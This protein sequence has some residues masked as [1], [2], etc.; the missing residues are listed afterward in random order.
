MSVFKKTNSKNTEI[1][2]QDYYEVKISAIWRGFKQEHISF[3][4][5]CAYFF[6]EYVRPQD[7]YPV[8]EI[9]PWGQIAL[10]ATLVTVFM[11]SSVKWVSNIENKLIMAF[12]IVVIMSGMLAFSPSVSWDNR[13][14]FLN[15]FLVYFLVINIV[16]TEKRLFIF[17]VLYLLFSFKMSQHGFVTLAKRGFA[18]TDWGLVGASGWVRN[19][20]EFAIQMLIFTSLSAA[21]VV[22]LK[23]NWGRYKAWFFYLMPMTGLFSILGS[24]SRGAQLALVII[25]LWIILKWKQRVRAIIALFFAAL[26]LLF[27]LP[28][29]QVKRFEEIGQDNTSLQRLAYWKLGVEIMGDHPVL[30]VGYYN[31]RTYGEYQH[32]DGVGPYG[33]MEWP[34]NIFIQAGAELGYTGLLLFLIM[35]LY[36]F[37]INVRS[38]KLAEEINNRFLYHLSYGLSA[39]LIGYLVSG[40]FVTVFYYPFFWVQLALSVVVYSV[41]NGQL[42]MQQRTKTNPDC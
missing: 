3:W 41:A 14:F 26:I 23:K 9:I 6:F 4:T 18:F 33:I 27:F 38:R 1:D 22:A 31:W 35:V 29:E 37:I 40:F 19:S 39:G 30:G 34:H 17:L 8:I 36:I 5:L 24:S 21:F 10:I 20:G 32:P 15:W 25:G 12:L 11:D 2:I 28:E 16:N 42:K 13:V 7:I